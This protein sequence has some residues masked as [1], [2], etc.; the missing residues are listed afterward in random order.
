M[1]SREEEHVSFYFTNN[2]VLFGS[3][4]LLGSTWKNDRFVIERN[5]YWDTRANAAG[6]R[7]NNGGL[8]QWQARGHDTNSVV[9]DP[10]FIDAR[11]AH[12]Q[13]K[14]ESPARKAGFKSIDLAGVGV[15]PKAARR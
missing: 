2:I 14:P 10:L 4:N 11:N 6:L 8:D 12:F 3:G 1:R 7:F 5:I 9:T 13:L 15:R